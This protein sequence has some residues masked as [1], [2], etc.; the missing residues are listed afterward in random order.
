MIPSRDGNH[1]T[2]GRRRV[3]E[4]LLPA[5][6]R[7][8]RRRRGR[9]CGCAVILGETPDP[10]GGAGGRRDVECIGRDEGG[11]NRVPHVSISAHAILERRDMPLNQPLFLALT[12]ITG[13]TSPSIV[14]VNCPVPAPVVTL[15]IDIVGET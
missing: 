12:L 14:T 13:E 7:D 9:R 11:L 5:R 15:K 3:P 4:I 8:D 2:A 6:L 10:D 1:E